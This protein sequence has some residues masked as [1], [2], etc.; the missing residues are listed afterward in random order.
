VTSS[1]PAVLSR[2]ALTPDRLGASLDVL[3]IAAV[4]YGVRL[5]AHRFG[6][7]ANVGSVAIVLAVGVATWLL[8]R[9]GESWR[10]IGFVRPPDL[11]RAAAWT[12]ATFLIVMLLPVVLEPLS[13]ALALPPQRL[14]RL[15]DI[16]GSTG[17]YLVLLIPIGWGTAAFGEE[18]IFRGFLNTRLATAFGGGRA[19][20][21]AA[22]VGQAL[23][24]GL[25]HMYLGPRGVLNTSLIGLVTAVV[26]L[27]GGRNLW[28]VIIAHGLVDTLGLTLLRLGI[29]HG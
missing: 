6:F 16:T 20:W 15:G 27:A 10:S 7:V 19:A 11:G 9:R 2:P 17:R 3:M 8:A 25:V 1:P 24:F 22:A 14:E 21:A 28:P 5:V 29:G 23:L 13:V 18:L 12:I 4:L 26:Y